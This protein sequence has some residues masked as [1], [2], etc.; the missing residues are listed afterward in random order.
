MS[1]INIKHILLIL[2]LTFLSC[3]NI[4]AQKKHQTISKGQT[5]GYHEDGDVQYMYSTA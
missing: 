1:R 2:G 5:S 4:Y 3:G